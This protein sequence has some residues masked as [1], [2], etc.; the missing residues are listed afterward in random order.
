MNLRT[1]IK[2]LMLKFKLDQEV[3]DSIYTAI[4]N[5]TAER[6]KIENFEFITAARKDPNYPIRAIIKEDGAGRGIACTIDGHNMVQNKTAKEIIKFIVEFNKAQ[7]EKLYAGGDK[8]VRRNSHLRG[9]NDK[10]PGD[11]STN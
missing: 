6:F 3:T 1:R 5:C 2:L 10:N 4:E 7:R 8:E 11:D 9:R